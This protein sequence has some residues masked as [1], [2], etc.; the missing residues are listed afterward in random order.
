[1]PS[2]FLSG[3]AP[4]AAPAPSPDG[5]RPSDEA[6]GSDRPDATP[7]PPENPDGSPVVDSP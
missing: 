7:R 5:F 4:N 3:S 6:S 1:M 2:K